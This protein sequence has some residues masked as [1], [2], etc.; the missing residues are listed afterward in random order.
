VKWINAP[1][2]YVM[3]DLD[4]RMDADGARIAGRVPEWPGCTVF[5]ISRSA[6]LIS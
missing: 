1:N 6:P 4:G 5:E 2:G 3:V